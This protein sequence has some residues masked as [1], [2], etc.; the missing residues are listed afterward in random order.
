MRTKY[1]SPDPLNRRKHPPLNSGLLLAI[2]QWNIPRLCKNSLFLHYHRMIPWRIPGGRIV[3][4]ILSFCSCLFLSILILFRGVDEGLL[5]VTVNRVH[6]EKNGMRNSCIT[7]E[8]HH[9]R[10]KLL[11]GVSVFNDNSIRETVRDLDTES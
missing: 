6:P 5:F 11:S 1:P 8:T 3:S 7:L 4:M 10:K 2:G 9:Q